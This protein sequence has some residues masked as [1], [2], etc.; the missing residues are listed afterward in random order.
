MQ[1][2]SVNYFKIMMEVSPSFF[3][4]E[5]FQTL[6]LAIAKPIQTLADKILYQMQHDSRVIYL[7]K[8]LNEYF[9][10][11][12]YNPN[13]HEATRKIYIVDVAAVPETYIFQPEENKPVYLGSVYLDRETASN[14]QFI[15]KI[16]N[17]ITY[18]EARLRAL[19]DYYKL[20]G[21]RYII[22]TY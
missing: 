2:I 20:A 12:T 10:I 19:I 21:K 5:A 15:V 17:E 16:P 13:S 1:W 22:E 9:E 6:N 11:A 7:E 4:G 8:V 14:F 3:Y 18:D